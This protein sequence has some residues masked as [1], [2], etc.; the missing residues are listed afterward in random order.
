MPPAGFEPAIPASERPQT[1]ALDRAA[2]VIGL[3]KEHSLH[4]SFCTHKTTYVVYVTL[5]SAVTGYDRPFSVTQYLEIPHKACVIEAA[6]SAGTV[7]G[8]ADP[9]K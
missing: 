3:I 7:L 4:R 6:G 9:V 8:P 5:R 2:T 1:H